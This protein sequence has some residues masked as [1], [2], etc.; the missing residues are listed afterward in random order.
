MKKKILTIFIPPVLIAAVILDFFSCG[1]NDATEIL[2]V[3]PESLT[4]NSVSYPELNSIGDV[5]KG[6]AEEYSASTGNKVKIHVMPI[7]KGSEKESV[8]DK[9]GTDA[10]VDILYD[11]FFN[12]SSYIHSG[13]AVPLD[14]VLTTEQM[15]DLH[16][17]YLE[18]GK[19]GGK[20]YMLPYLARQN[21]LMYNK[22]LLKDC[23][24]TGDVVADTGGFTIQ[25]WKMDRFT[26][27][28]DKIAGKE[29]E[30]EEH[31]NEHPK[32]YIPMMMYAGNE[33]GDTHIMTMIRAFG[34]NIFDEKG[35][36][37]FRDK[38]A[39]DTL[40][41]MQSG[42]DKK[43]YIHPV[44]N[45][46]MD[47]CSSKFKDGELGFYNFN[48]GSSIYELAVNGGSEKYGFVNYPGGNCT[49]FCDG[50]EIFDNGDANKIKA[51]KD[52]LRFFYSSEKWM[53]CAAGCLPASRKVEQ[54]YK[55]E[56]F[57]FEEFA[58]NSKNAVD[59]SNSLPNWQGHENSVRS[60]FYKEMQKLF[61]QKGDGEF[62]YTPEQCAAIL[63]EKLNESITI[64]RNSSSPHP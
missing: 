12:M 36:F 37:H 9:F 61:T 13:N 22:E 56:I 53:D 3:Y 16:E 33:Q 5:L 18:S 24:V 57:M 62:L 42:V 27:I 50:F 51:A 20:Q 14:D 19:Y 58:N 55:D 34:S 40:R 45:Q 30:R 60:R 52:F 29:K 35:S 41:W 54:K 49:F 11:D 8:T 15:S 48:L 46:T 47:A 21:I 28:L 44:E 4:T 7:G 25:T 43:W 10:A 32:G 6:A 31:P 63:D 64:G 26:E 59:F 17:Q 38:N 39:I 1:K 2:L 23:G